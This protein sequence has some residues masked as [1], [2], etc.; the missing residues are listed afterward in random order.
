MLECLLQSLLHLL[1][2]LVDNVSKA[3]VQRDRKQSVQEPPTAFASLK[4]ESRM[5]DQ[6]ALAAYT[7]LSTVTEPFSSTHLLS[8]GINTLAHL[9]F[10]ETDI[11]LP[12]VAQAYIPAR[13][14]S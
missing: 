2:G 5:S 7:Y 1:I 12:S 4:D 10:V 8:S 3:L 14:S 11:L 6:M 9:V 13:V